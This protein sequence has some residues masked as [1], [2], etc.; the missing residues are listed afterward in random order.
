MRALLLGFA[1]CAAPWLCGASPQDWSQA[2][3][4]F[5]GETHGNPAHH[6]RQA[7]LTAEVAPAA[8]VF[9]MLTEAQA[10][11][12]QPDLINEAKALA[13]ALDWAESGWPDFSLYYPIFAAAPQARIYGAGVPRAAARAAMSDGGLAA[14]GTDA[15]RYGLDQPL[16]SAQQA[17]RE[18][19]QA[20]VHCD[21]LPP[22]MLPMMVA[23]QRLRD[24]YLAR[25]AD[26]ALSETGGPVVVITGNGHA[27]RD[28]G[29]PVYLSHARPNVVQFS[30][31]QSEDGQILG[32]FDTQ[33]DSPRH[34]R[35]DPCAA[36]ASDS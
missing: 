13:R 25:A 24:A 18:K 8:I 33:A 1:L 11:K 35:E 10:K 34:D 26:R 15:S 28:W 19:L 30:L 32:A 2:E 20:Q 16:P 6:S 12:V 9:E 36:F 23:I 27:R 4:V 31:G 22:E 3:V 14:F 5:L 17:R 29:A 21:A 7:E